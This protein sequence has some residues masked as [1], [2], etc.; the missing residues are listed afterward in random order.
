MIAE[1]GHEAA[2]F[3]SAGE[4][5]SWVGCCP[6]REESAAASKSNRSTKGNRQMRRVLTQVAQASVKTQGS[7]FQGL[8]RGLVGRRGH[9]RAMWAVVHP[10]S[11]S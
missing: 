4:L 8:F 9:H 2:T 1:V 5:A 10:K 3:P 6:G 11:G 7:V